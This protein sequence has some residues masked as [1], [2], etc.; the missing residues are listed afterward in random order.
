MQ[1]EHL[2]PRQT[3]AGGRPAGSG[4]TPETWRLLG[5]ALGS[6]GVA[7]TH[8]AKDGIPEA[9]RPPL[10]P[11]ASTT[12]R[13]FPSACTAP[14]MPRQRTVPGSRRQTAPRAVRS[15]RTRLVGRLP[16]SRSKALFRLPGLRLRPHPA[17]CQVAILAHNWDLSPSQG[18]R[19]RAPSGLAPPPSWYP[20]LFSTEYLGF[21]TRAQGWRHVS[22]ASLVTQWQATRAGAVRH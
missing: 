1:T 15:D 12:S 14:P 7:R 13:P 9:C 10:H 20:L 11:P 2:L 21:H 5:G 4:P 17:A 16:S 8:L 22:T 3:T 6:W 19:R 18:R